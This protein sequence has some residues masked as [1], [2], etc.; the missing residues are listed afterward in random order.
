MKSNWKFN[1]SARDQ[2]RLSYLIGYLENEN[3]LKSLIGIDGSSFDFTKLSAE[4][5]TSYLY[6]LTRNLHRGKPD[7]IGQD[8]FYSGIAYKTTVLKHILNKTV[9][10]YIPKIEKLLVPKFYHDRKDQFPKGTNFCGRKKRN[11]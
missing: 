3:M 5:K 6:R 10:F 1:D 4:I 7:V 11:R 9:L 2:S 8:L